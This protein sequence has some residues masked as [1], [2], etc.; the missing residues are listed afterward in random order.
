MYNILNFIHTSNFYS[1]DQANGLA[2]IARSLQYSPCEFGVM[3][4]NFN[5]IQP[6]SEKIFSEVL[7]TKVTISDSS[8]IFYKPNNGIHFD[9]FSDFSRWKFVV[10]VEPSI[11]TMFYHNSGAKSALERY[12]FNY[13]NL[14]DWEYQTQ[15]LMEP[16]QGL[17]Y[18]PWMFH[19]LASGSIVQ[20]FDIITSSKSVSKTILVM[21][22]EKSGKTTLAKQLA[23]KTNS[24]YL[25]SDDVNE[26]YKDTDTSIEGENAQAIRL[27][28]LGVLAD[29]E[30]TIIDFKCERQSSRDYL[31]PDFVI[32]M[33]TVENKSS[34]FEE[35]TKAGL[36][37]TSFDYG[38]DLILTGLFGLN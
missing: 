10:A 31:A 34:I 22:S 21:G 8:G 3:T 26:I 14:F 35:P 38:I 13:N 4:E 1:T 33:D 29:T 32:W 20:M 7:N 11:F 16:G 30:F 24:T 6:D 27:Q 9:S 36:V 25:N 17:F 28:R 15:I 23:S 19:S 18:R 12:D 5:Y 2:D 37:I